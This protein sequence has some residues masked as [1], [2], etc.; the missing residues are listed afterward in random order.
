MS[1]RYTQRGIV[2]NRSKI[3]RE[4]LEARNLRLIKHFH[5]PNMA[6]PNPS[7]MSRIST[8]SHTWKQGDR[9]YKLAHKHYGDKRL[10]WLIAWFNLAPTESHVV[11]G[12][13]VQIPMPLEAAL[14][15]LREK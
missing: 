6:Y 14:S 8:I 5:T 7:Q 10:W 12:Q 11:T 2:T 3:Y 4:Q 1:N 9:Y 13:I 15:F